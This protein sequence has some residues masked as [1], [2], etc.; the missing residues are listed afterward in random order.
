VREVHLVL[1]EEHGTWGA[2]SPTLEGLFVT[3]D[4]AREA[5]LWAKKAAEWELGEPVDILSHHDG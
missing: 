4:S 3:A 2:W 1:R 5:M